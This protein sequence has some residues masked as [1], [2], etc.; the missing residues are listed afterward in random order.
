MHK[1]GRCKGTYVYAGQYVSQIKIDE[2]DLT[3]GR[4][5]VRMDLDDKYYYENISELTGVPIAG[6]Y[7]LDLP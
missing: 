1:T 5:T 4:V 6:E 7:E 2:T 3:T